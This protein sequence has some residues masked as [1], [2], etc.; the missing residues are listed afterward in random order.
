MTYRIIKIQQKAAVQRIPVEQYKNKNT[1]FMFP[2]FF[3][4]ML[5]DFPGCLRVGFLIIEFHCHEL[6]DYICLVQNGI[7]LFLIH[8]VNECSV[9]LFLVFVTHL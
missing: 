8:A 3:L 4:Q 2:L 5:R 7:L 1:V 6:A 9:F